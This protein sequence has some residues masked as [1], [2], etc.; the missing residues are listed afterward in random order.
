MSSWRTIRVVNLPDGG[1]FPGQRLVGRRDL[2]QS[3]L[4]AG[5]LRTLR[6]QHIALLT[7]P[8]FTGWQQT[9]MRNQD[10]LVFPGLTSLTTMRHLC[11]TKRPVS[12]HFATTRRRQRRNYSAP[13]A[14]HNGA[15]ADTF[16]IL[17]QWLQRHEQFPIKQRVLQLA[18]KVTNPQMLQQLVLA[19]ARMNMIRVALLRV[20]AAPNKKQPERLA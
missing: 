11:L 13:G 1:L 8:F 14:P 19:N 18:D 2:A 17:S 10:K 16:T 5:L 4:A 9:L 12:V 7:R 3:M 15:V 20:V 6:G